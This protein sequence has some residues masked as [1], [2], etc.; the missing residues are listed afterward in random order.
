MTEMGRVPVHR[1]EHRMTGSDH[2]SARH[3]AVGFQDGASIDV[4]TP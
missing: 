3:R 1:P 2:E 4:I